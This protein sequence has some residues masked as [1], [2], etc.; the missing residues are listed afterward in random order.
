LFTEPDPNDAPKGEDFTA[1]INPQSLE[2][3]KIFV[4]PDLAHAKVGNSYQFMRQGY[5]AL[6]PDSTADKLIFNRTIT[7]RDS[8]AKLQK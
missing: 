1:N 5:F 3:V 4:E 6:D 2:V 8:W 7:L